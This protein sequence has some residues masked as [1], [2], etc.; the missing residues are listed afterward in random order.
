MIKDIL[1]VAAGGSIGSV[2]RYLVQRSA[3]IAQIGAFPVGTLTVNFT[4]C[5]LIGVF[6]GLASR[7][8]SFGHSWQLFLM[9]GVC[10]G[11]TT[12]SAFTLESMGML[13]E[14]RSGSFFVYLFASVASGLAATYFGI[15]ISR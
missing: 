15:R 8:A 4:G 14:G 11:F 5:F 13:R 1:L 9:T 6:W 2:L 3:V 7:S 12:F 10:G